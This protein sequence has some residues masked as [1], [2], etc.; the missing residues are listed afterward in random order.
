MQSWFAL[1]FQHFKYFHICLNEMWLWPTD[2]CLS[3]DCKS[4]FCN[5][6]LVVSGSEWAYLK[7][8]WQSRT[9]T[10]R[11][12]FIWEHK[13]GFTESGW[14]WSS[15]KVLKYW[16]QGSH[17][18]T[19]SHAWNFQRLSVSKKRVEA[20]VLKCF[21]LCFRTVQE[22]R[23]VSISWPG[24]CWQNDATAHAE[25]WQ[26]GTACA[27]FTSKWVDATFS[28]THMHIH[29]CSLGYVWKQSM[30]LFNIMWCF[31]F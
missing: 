26:I 2:G 20:C 28:H 19:F 4:R 25:R 1:D 16:P 31:F 10:H 13:K 12:T 6:D 22:I 17:V 30:Q 8:L 3:K 7:N 14:F 15:L 11:I 27:N 18:M 29:T 9:K 24:Q 21:W 23:Q 5:P